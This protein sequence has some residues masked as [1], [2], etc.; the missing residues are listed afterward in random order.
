MPFADLDIALVYAQE[1][2]PPVRVHPAA[3]FGVEL[4]ERQRTGNP[5]RV[6]VRSGGRLLT[7]PVQYRLWE[8]S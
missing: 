4:S 5:F 7:G 8:E 1:Q 3:W 2:R 6:F